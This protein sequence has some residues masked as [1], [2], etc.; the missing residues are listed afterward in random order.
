MKTADDI[1]ALQPLDEH[2]QTLLQHVHPPDWV[3]PEP[4]GRYNMV[5]IGAG[6]AGLVTSAIVAGLGGKVALIERDLLGGDCLNVGCVPSKALLRC[7][8]AAADVRRAGEFG[9]RVSGVSVDFPAVMERMR[10]LRAQIAP[11]DSATRFRDMGVDVF[12]GEGRFTGPDTAEVEGTTLRFARACIATGARATELPIPGLADVGYLT[13]ET[14]FSLTELP[15]RLAVIGAGPIGCELA[16][17]FARFGSEVHLIEVMDAILPREDADAAAI[18]DAALRRDGVDVIT[19]GRD[20]SFAVDP[21]GKRVSVK[22][23][24]EVREFVV[25]EVLLGVGR[26]PNVEGLG[27]DA[28]GVEHD[29][30]GVKVDDRLQTTNKSIYAAGDI[31]SSYKFTHAADFMARTVVSNALFFGRGK[32]SALTIPWCTY[33]DPEIAHVGLYPADAEKQGIEIDTFTVEHDDVDRAILEGD[34]EGFVRVHVRKGTD[35]I[36]G[37][38]IVA[39]HAGD[40]ISQVTLALGAGAGLGRISKTIH[41]Y[42]TAADAIRK[43]GDLY[44]RTRLTP[45]AAKL[46][47]SILKWRR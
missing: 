39:P 45:R 23:N 18:V 4:D 21:D 36:V 47:A 22:A 13:N 14:V 46:L 8:R 32:A 26:A 43:T 41:P 40:L 44:N 29:R 2:N 5:V 19:A 17:A 28:A 31:C 7:A 37:A 10:R 38:T 3:N 30:D 34:E 20:L 33:T 1:P 11:N 6:A 12:I 25:D 15:R 16:Q 35:K 27:L 9:V 24:G 42:P